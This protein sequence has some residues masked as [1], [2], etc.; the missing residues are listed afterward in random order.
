MLEVLRELVDALHGL[1]A[2]TGNRRAELHAVLDQ[3]AED[4][5][6]AEAAEAPEVTPSAP[7][8]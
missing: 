7:P 3:A 1:K 6:P 5:A 4:T 8:A 2:I